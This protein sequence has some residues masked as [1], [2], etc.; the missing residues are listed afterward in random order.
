MNKEK[1]IIFVINN[2]GLWPGYFCM[3]LVNLYL[4]TLQEYPNAKLQTIQANSVNEMRNFSCRYALG[5]R[6][7]SG[8]ENPARA[9]Y[10]V[11]LDTDHRYPPTFII[12]LMKHGKDV[13]TGCTSNRRHP[14]NQTQFK[15]FQKEIKAEENI[16]NPSGDEELMK[17][18]ASGPVG[19]IIKVDVLDKLKY[20][21]YT[22]EH[23]GTEEDKN[24]EAVRGGDIFFCKQLKDIGVD[25]WLDPKITFPHE[26]NNVFV[27]RGQLQL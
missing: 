19:M 22:I 3:D 16:A 20:P 13:V 11:Q 7:P 4:T 8:D 14:F 9:D 27:N 5:L 10:L 1:I 25:I 6:G 24:V 17:I 21:Y 12:D 26:V 18:D 15:K 2:T 23:I